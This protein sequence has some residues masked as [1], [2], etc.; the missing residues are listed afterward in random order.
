MS[1]R[2]TAARREAKLAGRRA[3]SWWRKLIR[4]SDDGRALAGARIAV[5]VAEFLDDRRG[6]SLSFSEQL[7]YCRANL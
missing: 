6:P 7:S 5:P 3:S 1:A 2:E 4:S